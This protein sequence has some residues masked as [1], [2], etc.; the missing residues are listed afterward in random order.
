MTLPDT[1]KMIHSQDWNEH[2][3]NFE[4]FFRVKH[5]LEE[6]D[7]IDFDYNTILIVEQAN[8]LAEMINA[9]YI[10]ENIVVNEEDVLK[11]KDNKTFR[12]N[13]CASIM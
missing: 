12:E 10:H 5:A 2:Y 3:K 13:L 1:I 4:R 6:L 7:P 11:W 9:S 8:W